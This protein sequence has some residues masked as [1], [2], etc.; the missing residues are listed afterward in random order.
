MRNVWFPLLLI[1]LIS[2]SGFAQREPTEARRPTATQR[3]EMMRQM[4]LIGPGPE[5]RELK[6]LAGSWDVKMFRGN[7]DLG[8]N[9]SATASMILGDRFLVID[10]RGTPSGRNTEFR[11]TIGFDRRHD[12]YVI[13]CLDTS[14]TYPVTARG[15]AS[16]SGIR[17]RGTDDDPMMKKMGY[18]EKKF[19]FDLDIQGDAEFTIETIYIDTRTEPEKLR[20]AF[21]YVFKRSK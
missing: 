3:A 21:R 13:L 15:K 19:A 14:G 20:P 17:L 7:S 10:G 2:D 16:E 18:G 5:H 4:Q 9:G 11:Y 6:S 12:Q 1:A 8:F